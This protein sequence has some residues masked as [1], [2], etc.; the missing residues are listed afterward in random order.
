M[1]HAL[2]EK[3]STLNLDSDNTLSK[4]VTAV[5]NNSIIFIHNSLPQGCFN[6]EFPFPVCVR[7]LQKKYREFKISTF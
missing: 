2:K 6:R 4:H 1:E 3:Q 5:N 7:R